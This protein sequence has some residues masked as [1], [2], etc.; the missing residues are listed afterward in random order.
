MK[1][2]DK[3]TAWEKLFRNASSGRVDRDVELQQYRTELLRNYEPFSIAFEALPSG[4]RVF[5]KTNAINNPIVRFQ[6]DW[7]VKIK[8][9]GDKY[10]FES[11]PPLSA[12]TDIW[13]NA[14]QPRYEE[15]KRMGFVP[16]L[17]DLTKGDRAIELG[18][19]ELKKKLSLPQDKALR[20]R[21]GKNSTDRAWRLWY[22]SA[23]PFPVLIPHP[24]D[25]ELLISMGI[26]STDNKLP[27]DPKKTSE[28]LT[29]LLDFVD[30]GK[31]SKDW[32][33]IMRSRGNKS[34]AL[35]NSKRKQASKV[36]REQMVSRYTRS[37]KIDD[38]AGNPFDA[39][40]FLQK[41]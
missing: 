8:P 38:K 16:V 2:S 5:P 10:E 11:L 20:D 40:G 29:E 18:I 31:V 25:L 6:K 27:W 7:A 19:R 4:V 23:R 36:F 37:P 21:R 15:L 1:K 35:R 24:A 34:A 30:P 9:A 28:R 13:P 14:I 39:W 3:L 32:L 33:E 17:L 12:V 22:A 26:E 41:K